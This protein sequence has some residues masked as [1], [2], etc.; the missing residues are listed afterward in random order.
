VDLQ[1]VKR[2]VRWNADYDMKRKLV[3]VRNVDDLITADTMPWRTIDEFEQ[4]RDLLEDWKR[5]RRRVLKT[6]QDYEDMIAWGAAR[7]SRRKTGTHGHNALPPVASAVLKLL[8]HH[9]AGVVT[10]LEGPIWRKAE[11]PKRNARTARLMTALCGVKVTET[12]AKDAKRRGAGPDDLVHS[13]ASFTDDDRRFL[14]AWF[15]LFPAAPEVLDI[16]EMICEQGSAASAE[17]DDLFLDATAFDTASG[18][19]DDPDA[20]HY[21]PFDDPGGTQTTSNCFPAALRRFMKMAWRGARRWFG[22]KFRK[23]RAN[24]TRGLERFGL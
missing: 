12:T 3:K 5:S 15:S 6:K 18:D 17:L 13:I 9:T 20:V 2:D 21:D 7:S 11:R 19:P 8:A 22:G 23:F 24:A 10:I 4:A 14:T 1:S 16:A